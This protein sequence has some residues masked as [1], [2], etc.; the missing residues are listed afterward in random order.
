MREL[1]S[2]HGSTAPKVLLV[3]AAREDMLCDA[4]GKRK[5]SEIEGQTVPPQPALVESGA[6]GSNSG[7]VLA[8]GGQISMG[9]LESMFQRLL[10]NQSRTMECT[11][12]RTIKQE[13]APIEQRLTSLE[14]GSAGYEARFVA[15]EAKIE[16]QVNANATASA[17]LMR[18]ISASQLHR[19]PASDQRDVHF[20]RVPDPTILWINTEGDKLVSTEAVVEGINAICQRGSIPLTDISVKSKGG[21][22]QDNNFVVSFGKGDKETGRLQVNKA[23]QC[24]KDENGK[25]L[26]LSVRSAEGLV[27]TYI[28]PDRNPRMVRTR[29]LTKK[30]EEAFKATHGEKKWFCDQ[31]SGDISHKFVP[32]VSV[33]VV[34][35]K[36]SKLEWNN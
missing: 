18:S 10:D 27:R 23:R 3:A 17:G 36:S 15:L 31:E 13:L 25:F 11:V 30:L 5:G 24:L 20:D 2:H 4:N 35:K 6:S 22:N 34:D 32:V 9:G 28:N 29:I 14:S 19:S 8:G 1:E 33:V 7:G 21:A 16:N 12:A 26:N